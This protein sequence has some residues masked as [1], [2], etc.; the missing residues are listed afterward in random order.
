MAAEKM[1]QKSH[2]VYLPEIIQTSW[3]GRLQKKSWERNDCLYV[4]S[5]SELRV[6]K[7]S[8]ENVPSLQNYLQTNS[9]VLFILK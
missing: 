9:L 6:K 1:L 7:P 8:T 4:V 2:R 5:V 3:L